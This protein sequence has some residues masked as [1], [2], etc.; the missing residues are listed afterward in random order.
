MVGKSAVW[1][2]NSAIRNSR[3]AFWAIDKG[4]DVFFQLELLDFGWERAVLPDSFPQLLGFTLSSRD[5]AGG[6][7]VFSDFFRPVNSGA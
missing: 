2:G 3:V 7:Q 5:G 6:L 1:T 4:H